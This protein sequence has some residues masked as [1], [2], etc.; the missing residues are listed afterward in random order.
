MEWYQS[1]ALMIGLLIAFMAL[2]VPVAFAFLA[3]SAIGMLVFIGGEAG[4]QQIAVNATA[5]ITHFVFVPIPLFILMGELF[6]HA[7]LA[8]RVFDAFDALFGRVPGRLSY[9]TVAGGTMFAT[10]SGTSMGS[11]AMLGSLLVPEMTRRGYKKYMS[12]GPILGAGGLAMIIPPSGLAVLLGSIAKV[13]IGRLLIAGVLP[14]LML[15]ALYVAMV[16]AQV[17]LD[18][19]AAPQYDVA[20]VA[21]PTRLRLVVT[22]L[23]PMSLIVFMVIG[24]IILGIATPTEAAAFGALGVVIL[25]AAFGTLTREAIVKSLTGTLRVTVMVLIIVLASSTFSQILTISGAS[26]GLVQWVSGLD[27]SPLGILIVMFFI[28][29]VMGM[30]MD[31]VSMMLITV[32]IFFPLAQA[33]GFD[34]IWFAIIVLLA[35]EISGVTPPFGL[36]LFVMLGVAPRGTTLGE[37]SRAVVPFVGCDILL[38]FLLLAF[39]WIATYL[40]G[41]ME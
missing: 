12:M 8:A 22:N 41:L 32:P 40:P 28:L 27:V 21:W 26:Q 29:L 17:R 5:S 3:V 35:L 39:P 36:G 31:Q 33:L 14:G 1:G 9:V 4:L 25:A 6:F 19:A 20:R 16:F 24:L 23:V 2:S 15:A 38:F 30:L 18:P 11:T 7:R 13:D 34:P 10:L 37:V